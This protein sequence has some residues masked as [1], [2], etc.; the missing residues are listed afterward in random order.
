MTAM[1]PETVTEALDAP[2]R[3]RKSGG[4]GW[5]LLAGIVLG[6]GVLGLW[7]WHDMDV[8]PVVTIPPAPPL[9][10]PNAEDTFVVAGSSLVFG[11]G[12]VSR[13]AQGSGLAIEPP[14]P[15]CVSLV[16]SNASALVEMRGGL[17]QQYGAS[18]LDPTSTA[19]SPITS[20]RI[21][22]RFVSFAVRTRVRQ[23]DWTSAIGTSLDGIAMGASMTG[24]VSSLSYLA[25]I[26]VQN[27]ARLNGWDAIPHLDGGTARASAE[28]MEHIIAERPGGLA[29]TFTDMKYRVQA[30]LLDTYYKP[31]TEM[32][33]AI[34]KAADLPYPN[35]TRVP[36][37]VKL[38]HKRNTMTAVT[39]YMDEVIAHVSQ[40][41]AWS[42]PPVPSPK[43]NKA[44][45][46]LVLDE[47]IVHRY[48]FKADYTICENHLF[49]LALALRAYQCDHGAAPATLKAL[50]PDYLT[51]VP[52]D[53]FAFD[54]AF[55]FRLAGTGYLLYSVGPDGVDDGGVAMTS[56]GVSDTSTGD[57]VAGVNR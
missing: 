15:D 33:S 12:P 21:L 37:S 22:G 11:T 53:P 24:R 16:E 5:L 36:L 40:P 39:R 6:I 35:K 8:I 31:R 34:V 23:E 48:L 55:R 44:A 42:E 45:S 54:G 49:L 9:P 57:I 28:R 29:L 2:A 50:V 4:K 32:A 43:G 19:P 56:K 41:Q 17:T 3:K 20:I 10:R 46:L 26:A 7:Y 30:F 51:T 47:G 18:K 25:G 52:A 1:E 13:A 27:T 14:L 38:L